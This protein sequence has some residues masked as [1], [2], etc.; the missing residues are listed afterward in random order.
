MNFIS[1]HNPD[2]SLPV[3]R[4][5]IGM[6]LLEVLDILGEFLWR[7][8]WA[9]FRPRCY[10]NDDAYRG[11][12]YRL[13]KKGLIV[14]RGRGVNTPTMRITERGKAL[15]GDA[16]N[17]KRLW[18]AGWNG[19]WYVLAYDVPERE[20]K[21]RNALR[22]FLKSMR[23]GRLQRSV[24]ITPR[25][26]RPDYDDLNKAGSLNEFAFLFE[27]K[28]VLGRRTVDVVSNAW[29]FDALG[30]KQRWYLDVCG[31][32]L[33]RVKKL[34]FRPEDLFTLAREES[35]AYTAVMENDPLLP[36]ELWPRG[37]SGEAA[38]ETHVR[39]NKEIGK[40]LKT[41]F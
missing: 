5:Q 18:N 24:W 41:G 36:R 32:N 14:C 1:F 20:K 19:I 4:R 3:L 34:E 40:R 29:D 9:F 35:S 33:E 37:Y 39:I 31:G 6:E 15:L 38:Y 10:P 16:R 11:A 13:R 23:M 26:I 22:Y 17:P 2:I 12:V 8:A 28:T 30:T 7:G 25:D 27:S 21:Y